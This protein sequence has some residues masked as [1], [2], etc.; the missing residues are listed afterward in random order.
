MLDQFGNIAEQAA[1]SISR[2]QLL[3][4]LGWTAMAMVLAAGANLLAPADL[5]AGRRI[6]GLNSVDECIGQP[7]GSLCHI[8]L[9][10]GVCK[11]T[12]GST[13]CLCRG[14]VKDPRA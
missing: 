6:C 11:R 14:K 5:Q 3:G 9:E 10:E 7:E 1:T 4:R 2:R 13:G 12:P 8:D